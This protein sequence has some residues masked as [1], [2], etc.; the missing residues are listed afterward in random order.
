MSALVSS[1]KSMLVPNSRAPSFDLPLGQSLYLDLIR[2][3][4]AFEVMLGHATAHRYTGRG[5][6]WQIDPFRH[7]QTAVVGFFVLS[8]F[9]IAF[10]ARARETGP[11][12]YTV[13]RVSRMHSVIIPAL[14]LTWAAD[15]LGQAVNPAFYTVPGFPTPIVDGQWLRYLLSF[16][17]VNHT[18]WLPAMHPGS[19]TPFWT[20]TH[21]VVYYA[22]FGVALFARG[23]WRIAGLLLLCVAGGL[24][25]VL[26]L[27]IWLLGVAAYQLQCRRRLGLPLGLLVFVSSLLGIVALSTAGPTIKPLFPWAAMLLYYAIGLL[28]A[29]NLWGAVSVTGLLEWG[30]HPAERLVR[31]LGM[32]TFALYLGHRPLLNLFSAWPIATPGHWMQHLW[33]FGGSFIVCVALA[34]AGEAL[35]PRLRR[36]L[37]PLVARFGK[38]LGAETP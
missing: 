35:R 21:E 15:T 20:M 18:G 1:V 4:M 29:L 26:Y 31:W 34:Y 22:I 12:A 25:V 11:A 6:L 23:G 2:F 8:G 19:N 28:M 5:F 7:L 33:L 17:Y 9:V 27:P 38:R 16:L 37:L 32:L 36:A 13:A 3:V 24:G 10:A 30:L 14:A